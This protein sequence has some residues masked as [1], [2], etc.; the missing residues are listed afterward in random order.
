[1]STMLPSLTT[2]LNQAKSAHDLMRKLGITK[3]TWEAHAAYVRSLHKDMSEMDSDQLAEFIENRHNHQSQ[4]LRAFLGELDKTIEAQKS[5][6]V[7]SESAR[8][9]KDRQDWEKKRRGT[10]G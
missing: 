3:V 4:M 10:R 6:R 5:A 9:M 8:D 1:M 7:F 2:M